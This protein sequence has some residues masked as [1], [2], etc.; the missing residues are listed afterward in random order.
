MEE[1][2]GAS[3]S[4]VEYVFKFDCF[5]GDKYHFRF[6]CSLG[7]DCHSTLESHKKLLQPDTEEV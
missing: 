2:P 6:D 4:L 7:F 3:R 1:A 5:L